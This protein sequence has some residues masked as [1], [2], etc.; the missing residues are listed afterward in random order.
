MSRNERHVVKNPNGGWDVK[1]PHAERASC[2]T[3]TKVEATSRAREICR[4]EK[5]ECIIHDKKGKIQDSNSYGRD[6]CPPR[7]KNK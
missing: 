4:N 7:D 6:P 2:H 1:K 3:E 5:A